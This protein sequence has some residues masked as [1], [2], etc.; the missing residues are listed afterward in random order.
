MRREKCGFLW[1]L[2]GDDGVG[3]CFFGGRYDIAKW[4]VE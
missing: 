1:T 3:L 4:C 2:L